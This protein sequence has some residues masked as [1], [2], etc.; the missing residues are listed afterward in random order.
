MMD[1]EHHLWACALQ[2]DRQHGSEARRFAEARIDAL[3]RSNDLD[4][5]LIWRQIKAMLDQLQTARRTQ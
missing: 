4:G 2:V 1:H 3:T 5:V